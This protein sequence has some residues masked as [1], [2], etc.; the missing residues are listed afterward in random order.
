[1]SMILVAKLH[2]VVSAMSLLAQMPQQA[3]PSLPHPEIPP[4]VEIGATLPWWAYLLGGIVIAGIVTLLMVLIFGRKGKEVV[5]AKRPLNDALRRMKDLRGRADVIE[6]GDVGHS[7]SAILR[8]Y[9]LDRYGIPAPFKTTEELFPRGS[10]DHEP[11]RRRQWRER[12]ESLAA[13]YDSLSYAPLPATRAEALA[14]VD[15]AINKLE[16]ER[17]HEHTLAA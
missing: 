9:Y 14:L 17:L 8:R 13:L 10:L 15:T 7:V 3:P 6:P 5:P 12:F 16:E 2:S 1:V 4:P 11:L